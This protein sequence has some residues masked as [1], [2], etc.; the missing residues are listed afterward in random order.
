[1]IVTA[2]RWDDRGGMTRAQ[3]AVK[4]FAIYC[5]GGASRVLGFYASERN[6]D[7]YGP[8]CVVYD[9]GRPEILGAL[10]ALFGDRALPFAPSADDASRIHAATSRFIHRAMETHGATALICFGQRILQ[11]SIIEAYPRALINFHPSL[12]PAFPGLRAIDRA[13]EAG[14][15]LLGNTAHLVDPGIDTGEV[16]AQSAMCRED[17]ESCEDLLELQYPLLKLVLRDVLGLPV[18]AA[19]IGAEIGH[20]RTPYL[21]PRRCRP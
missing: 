7:A 15:A 16:L 19:D 12:L 6:R 9:G 2:S 4:P 3:P 1:L 20:R 18:P 21:V 5:S 8:R 17:Y 10:H 14:V 13:L 11:R